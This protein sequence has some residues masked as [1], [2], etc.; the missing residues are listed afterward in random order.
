MQTRLTT[1]DEP[2]A[3]NFFV[4]RSGVCVYVTVQS[5]TFRVQFVTA[6]AQGVVAD[7]PHEG[8]DQALD[9][10]RSALQRHE[11]KLAPLFEKAARKAT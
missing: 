8:A 10:A 3:E 9:L 11:A 4:S 1:A 5:R 2:E 6:T 7:Q